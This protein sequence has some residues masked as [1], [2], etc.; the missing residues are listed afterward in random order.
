M[1]VFKGYRDACGQRQTDMTGC[2][3]LL[4]LVRLLEC[5]KRSRFSAAYENCLGIARWYVKWAVRP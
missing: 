4:A 3:G 5:P 1:M 2:G